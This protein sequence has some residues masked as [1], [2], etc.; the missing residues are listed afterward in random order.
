MERPVK[1]AETSSKSRV[2][3]VGVDGLVVAACRVVVVCLVLCMDVFE[4]GG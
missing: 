2:V 1:Q 4:G 3:S